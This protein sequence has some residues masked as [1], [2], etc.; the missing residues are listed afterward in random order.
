LIGDQF[1]TA[2]TAGANVLRDEAD[3]VGHEETRPRGG[4]SQTRCDPGQY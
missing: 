2:T 4:L 3:V 1:D